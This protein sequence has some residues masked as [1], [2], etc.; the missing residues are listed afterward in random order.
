VIFAVASRLGTIATL[1]DHEGVLLELLRNILAALHQFFLS[2]HEKH[3]AILRQLS[4]TGD[5]GDYTQNPGR[6]Q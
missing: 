5:S 2:G 4:K 6:G 1:V 3:F